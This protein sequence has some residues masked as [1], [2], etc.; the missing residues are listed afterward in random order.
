LKGSLDVSDESCIAT[1]LGI[2]A[3]QGFDPLN[4]CLDYKPTG[5]PQVFSPDQALGFLP[6]Q[7]SIKD[8]DSQLT[9]TTPHQ[10]PEIIDNL[11]VIFRRC[12]VRQIVGPKVGQL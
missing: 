2:F 5:P 4:C 12:P 10:S 11:F 1:P 8:S 6:C 9:A 3:G 7:T